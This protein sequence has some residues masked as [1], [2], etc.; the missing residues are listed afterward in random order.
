M[1]R[2]KITIAE[3]GYKQYIEALELTT[4]QAEE[5]EVIVITDADGYYITIPKSVWS[6]FVRHC[7]ALPLS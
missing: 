5:A 6:D 4:E 1:P 7:Q 3:A 2:N